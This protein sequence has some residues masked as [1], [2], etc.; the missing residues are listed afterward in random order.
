V[1]ALDDYITSHHMCSPPE[2][3]RAV[4]AAW[5]SG[6][7]DRRESMLA[8]FMRIRGVKAPCPKCDGFGVR[9]YA[10]TATW[11]GGMG[12]SAITDDVCDS[13]WG[14]GDA[15]RPWTDLRKIQAQF[16]KMTAEIRRLRIMAGVIE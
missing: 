5:D 15:K 16:E 7:W 14:S 9:A 8:D 12:G 1:N 13:C 11:R 2:L 10:S 6:S 4:R 3:I